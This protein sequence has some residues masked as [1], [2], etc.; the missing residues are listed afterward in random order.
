MPRSS[1]KRGEMRVIVRGHKTRDTNCGVR[2]RAESRGER[3]TKE[4]RK[5][6]GDAN[7]NEWS[8]HGPG[9]SHGPEN[10]ESVALRAQWH[11]GDLR[12]QYEDEQRGNERREAMGMR[13]KT[14]GP[15]QCQKDGRG[16]TVAR[17][18]RSKEHGAIGS[19][20][21]TKDQRDATVCA[22]HESDAMEHEATVCAEHEGRSDERDATIL[23][24][25]SHKASEKYSPMPRGFPIGHEKIEK[26]KGERGTE[27]KGKESRNMRKVY[28]QT[29]VVHP[30]KSKST[31]SAYKNHGV[32]AGEVDNDV[33]FVRY[34]V[35]QG[36]QNSASQLA[37]NSRGGAKEGRGECFENSRRTAG[38]RRESTIG[39]IAVGSQLVCDEH[40]VVWVR[41]LRGAGVG[42]LCG[43]NEGVTRYDAGPSMVLDTLLMSCNMHALDVALSRSSSVGQTISW[44]R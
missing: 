9:A 14:E 6:R 10:V 32:G 37:R 30:R 5:M 3:F 18:A 43:G 13:S 17:R 29:G 15:P 44:K 8:G 4:R 1:A 24:D 23:A 38:R 21:R 2:T 26:E 40:H 34:N 27:W 20:Q 19:V 36:S 22:E 28:D 31:V 33:I 7:T 35:V 16:A 41:R 42:C 11:R 12:R 25:V 39:S